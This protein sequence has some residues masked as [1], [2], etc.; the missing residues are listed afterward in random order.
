M[1]TMALKLYN[2]LTRKKE[3]FT[4]LV[5][6]KVGMYVCG[7]TVYDSCHLGHAR[8][9][10]T[11]DMIS[12]Y[13]RFAGFD[14]K[15]VTNF[16]DVDDKII[17]RANAE[18]VSS[19]E[20]SERYI[21]EYKQDMAALGIETPTEL[22]KATEHITEM[23]DMIQKLISRNVA[24]AVDGSVFFSVRAFP[25]YGKLSGKKIE[26]LEVGARIEVDEAKKDPL[27]FVLWKP[28]KSG[29]P[30]WD[31]PWGKGRPGW[32]IECSAMS[33]KYLGETFDIHGGGR[34]ISFPHHE[35]EIAQSEGA[36]GKTFAR[37]WLHNG[38][39]TMNGEKMSKSLGN[40]E[41]IQ[42]LVKKYDP[43][44]IRLFVFSNHYRSPLDYTEQNM[45]DSKSA[46][47]RYYETI[48]RVQ[49]SPEASASS[50][51]EAELKTKLADF[52]K[53]FA[54]AMNDDFNTAVV[55][56]KVFELVRMINR[57]LDEAKGVSAWLKTGVD[58]LQKI[59]SQVLGVFGSN[60]KQYFAEASR[61]V[62]ES[63]DVKKIEDLIAKRQQAR[64]N[65]DFAESDKIRDQLLA[66]GV[67]LK[68]LPGGK[69]EW[70]VK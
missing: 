45:S 27:D 31:S 10:L 1:K 57:F 36:S 21:T 55:I 64:A 22:P 49:L 8:A 13:L 29:E 40:V 2:T 32:H 44:V 68:D 7:V 33:C 56:G 38:M 14:V 19:E 9:A 12:R 50:S 26:D 37:Y 46:L 42:Q 11:F 67:E 65:K 34:D 41:N 3:I 43:E 25:E 5:E 54:E 70:K 15:Y 17:K 4:P 58:E 35:N 48:A 24:Y 18:H 20:I 69:V 28:A 6:N 52:S 53:D 61:R 30:S 39:I 51:V 16:T 62:H 23:I 59:L 63:V 47:D 60:P 66:M